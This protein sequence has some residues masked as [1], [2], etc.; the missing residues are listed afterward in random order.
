MNLTKKQIEII[1]SCTPAKLKG[2]Q[3]SISRT[4]GYCTPYGANWSY[5]AGFVEYKGQYVLVVTE[6]GTII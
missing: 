5:N 4:L 6:F 2:K 1:R 3:L